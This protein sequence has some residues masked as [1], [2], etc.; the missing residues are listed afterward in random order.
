MAHRKVMALEERA[1]EEMRMGARG[2]TVVRPIRTKTIMYRRPVH[3]TD[4]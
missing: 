4:Y 3:E 1:N 2:W